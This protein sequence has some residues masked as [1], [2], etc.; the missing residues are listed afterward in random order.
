MDTYPAGSIVKV[1]I[2]AF[3]GSPGTPSPGADGIVC[4]ISH[5]N[6]VPQ[7]YVVKVDANA[8]PLTP[9]GNVG[10]YVFA[11]AILGLVK[12]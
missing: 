3:T 9:G 11:P 2:G 1:W 7:A 10:M 8:G 5:W 6:T 4:R 12:T